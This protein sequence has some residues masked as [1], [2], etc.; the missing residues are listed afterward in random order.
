MQMKPEH[1]HIHKD[2]YMKLLIV[3]LGFMLLPLPPA[4][5][6]EPTAPAAALASLDQLTARWIEL[7]TTIAEEER[8]WRAQRDQWQR[9]LALLQEQDTTL[10]KEIAEGQVFASSVEQER[11]AVIARKE[12]MEHELQQLRQVL[13]RAEADLKQWETLLPDGLRAPL[14]AAFRSLPANQTAA[15]RMQVSRRVQNV[16][17]LYSQIEALHN[18]FHATSETLE[19]G[20]GIRRQVDV[21]YIGLA[22]A[23]AVAPGNDWAAIGTPSAGGW[24]WTP[25]TENAAAI[26]KAIDV[27]N[28]RQTAQLVTLP[29]QIRGEEQ[30]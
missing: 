8:T 7:R 3:L 14:S 15:D 12:S 9:E 19:A 28:R 16:V 27:L 10:K 23:F 1:R 29:M 17:M 24:Q 18:G 11:S 26:R 21:L 22:R 6:G 13:D 20:S 4:A 25:A 30:P 5:A 2:N